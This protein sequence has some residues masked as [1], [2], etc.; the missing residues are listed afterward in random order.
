VH[1]ADPGTS[2]KYELKQNYPNP[3]NPATTISFSVAG[4][5]HV[6][7]NVYES[8][9]RLVTTLIDREMSPGNYS[10]AWAG[11]S[12]RGAKVASGVYFLRLQTGTFDAVREI[13]ILK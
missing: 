9:G 4:K 2:L 6:K 1:P 3:F 13:L 11:V 8:L 5:D 10:T 12:A 7:F